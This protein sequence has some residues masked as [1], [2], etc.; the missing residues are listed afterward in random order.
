MERLHN[1][2]IGDNIRRNRIPAAHVTENQIIEFAN[3]IGRRMA[4]AVTNAGQLLFLYRIIKE[5]NEFSDSYTLHWSNPSD[6]WELHSGTAVYSFQLPPKIMKLWLENSTNALELKKQAINYK[7]G[8]LSSMIV[9]YLHDY[10]P[11][12]KMISIDKYDLEQA[13]QNLQR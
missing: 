2:F 8:Y 6:P 13:R 5:K 12:V 1:V 10:L 4:V 11:T 9:Y 3:E 7:A